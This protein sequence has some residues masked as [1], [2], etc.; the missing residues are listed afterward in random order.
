MAVD[1]RDPRMTSGPD[2]YAGEAEIH[3][4]LRRRL[5]QQDVG[6]FLD[7]VR[8]SGGPLLELASG[9]G[10]LLLPLARE[11]ASAV[12][13]D[14]SPAMLREC[15]QRRAGHGLDEQVELVL[16]DIRTIR[17]G[18]R[19]RTVV[20]GGQSLAFMHSDEDLFAA[21]ETVRAHLEPDGV[22]A[23]AMPVPR[24]E[25]L[26]QSQHQLKLVD[27][28]VAEDGRR[29]VVWNYSFADPV[30]QLATL[31]RIIEV[32]DDDGVVVERRHVVHEMTFRYPG[33]LRRLLQGAGF[34]LKEVYGGYD[35]RPFDSSAQH[36]VWIAVPS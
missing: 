29:T 24:F 35:R 28:F 26:A 3:D 12:G 33:E 4:H 15:E 17:L 25:E 19:F 1:Q 18:R 7:V 21:L 14:N 16:G 8:D 31:R 30:R 5:T 34:T 32:L 11:V 36:F 20:I 23:A 2:A 6:F 22:L 13:V 27:D 9:T 10:R